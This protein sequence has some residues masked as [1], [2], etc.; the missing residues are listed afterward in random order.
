[1]RTGGDICKA[2]ACGADAVMIGSPF[3][4]R[5]RGARPR[6]PLGHGHAHATLPRG[7]PREAQPGARSSRSSSAPRTRTARSTWSARSRTSMATT[8]SANVKEFQK[9]E[10]VIA[11]SI[12]T[13]GKSLPDAPSAGDGPAEPDPAV[14]ERRP[15]TGPRRRLRGAVH[16]AHRPPHPRGA[17]LLR[18]RRRTTTPLEELPREAPRRHRAL[19]RPGV[20]LRRRRAAVDPGAVRPRRPGARHLLR[21]PA[22]GHPRRRGRRHRAA[23]VRRHRRCTSPAAGVA[24]ARTSPST[25]RCG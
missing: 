7:A 14:A 13:E 19:G 2:I 4:A 1:M 16:A 23:R 18:D 8:G 20:R 3:A 25:S 24:P 15:A 5:E 10:L 9:A 11:P 6:L 22:H 17:R 21:P 12:K